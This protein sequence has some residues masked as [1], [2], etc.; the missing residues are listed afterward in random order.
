MLSIQVTDIKDCMQ[1]L[2]SGDCFDQFYLV[3][4]TVQMGIS[5]YLD[6]HLNH[7]FYDSETNESIS[8]D[9]CFWKE[10]RPL[11]FQIIRGRRLPLGFKTVLALPEKS[12]EFLLR[13][14]QGS[15]TADDIEGI[16]VNIRFEP[17][18]LQI[19]TGIS[20]RTFSL[21]RSLEHCVDDHIASF[22]KKHGI[23]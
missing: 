1:K 23:C 21:D 16:Y 7:D 10:A 9:Y 19:T 2:L 17:G 4:T 13:E 11:V 20:Y 12:V 14:S 15:Y 8:R 18:S 3:E 5:Y 22:L 6:G